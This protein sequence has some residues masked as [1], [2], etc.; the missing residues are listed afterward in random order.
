VKSKTQQKNLSYIRSLKERVEKLRKEANNWE[1]RSQI[2][3]R[4]RDIDNPSR[5]LRIITKIASKMKLTEREKKRLI[6]L[7]K[8]RLS[9]LKKHFLSVYNII[10]KNPSRIWDKR[11]KITEKELEERVAIYER[12][13]PLI[14]QKKSKKPKK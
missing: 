13:L 11:I 6:G 9:S 1:V 4:I 8:R 14:F 3:K 12:I 7:T 5:S 2:S 10:Q